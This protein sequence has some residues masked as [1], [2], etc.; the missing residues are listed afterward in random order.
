MPDDLSNI[1]LCCGD[2][3]CLVPNSD[4]L[5]IFDIL[6]IHMSVTMRHCLTNRG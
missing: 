6:A 4:R 1:P 3:L 5:D 2:I